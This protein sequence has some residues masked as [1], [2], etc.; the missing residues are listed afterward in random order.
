M[1]L[2][3]IDRPEKLAQAWLSDSLSAWDAIAVLLH[4][5]DHDTV[6]AWME[7]L[8]PDLA[9]I[10]LDEICQLALA[11]TTFTVGRG[12]GLEERPEAMAALLGWSY[13]APPLAA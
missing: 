2:K 3:D 1:A 4:R 12:A 6:S 7:A 8:P 13:R 9:A 11:A 5:V 10:T